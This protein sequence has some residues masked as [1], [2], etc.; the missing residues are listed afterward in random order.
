MCK[1]NVYGDISHSHSLT[2]VLGGTKH[3]SYS[4]SESVSVSSEKVRSEVEMLAYALLCSSNHLGT[5][6][7]PP[8]AA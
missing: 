8:G 4:P 3:V 6:A 1:H 7:S 2:T 5:L